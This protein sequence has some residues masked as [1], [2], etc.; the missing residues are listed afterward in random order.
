M[1]SLTIRPARSRSAAGNP[2]SSPNPP[3]QFLEGEC[4]KNCMFTLYRTV[5]PARGEIE[6]TKVESAAEASRCRSRIQQGQA[7]KRVAAS[8]HSRQ[9]QTVTVESPATRSA[10]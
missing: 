7:Y 2:S 4:H 3:P 8:R 10:S 9:G 6:K 1:A 5:L